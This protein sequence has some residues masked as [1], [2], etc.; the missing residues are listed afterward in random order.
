MG[1]G[2]FSVTNSAPW[3]ASIEFTGTYAGTSPDLLTV[4]ALNPPAGDLTFTISF[5]NATLLSWL[6]SQAVITVPLQVWINV[7]NGRRCR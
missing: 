3:T 2:N 1:T 5:A 7:L 4:T 6:R